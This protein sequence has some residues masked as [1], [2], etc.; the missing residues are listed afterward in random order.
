[1]TRA[2]QV[3]HYE[4]V[5]STNMVLRRLA[6]GGAPE[7]TVVWADRQTAGRGRTG[8]AWHSGGEWGLWF[9]ML[10]RPACAL[11]AQAGG[12]LPISAGV[13]VARSLSARLGLV[14]KIELKW[15]ND[16]LLGGRKVCGILCEAG[17]SGPAVDW[18]VVGV[19]I[20][21][22]TPPDGF[23]GEIGRTATALDQ[24][25]AAET[26]PSRAELLS[27][28]AAAVVEAYEQLVSE[29]PQPICAAATELMCSMIGRTVTCT[30]PYGLLSGRV[31]GLG[32]DGT[33][34][35]VGE[36]GGRFSVNA[37]DVHIGTRRFIEGD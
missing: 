16:V 30:T 1:M 37:G 11:P 21:V 25:M 2:L 35:L 14:G 4:E 5:D 8:R 23:P 26:L 24:H 6:C 9:S 32:P 10:L 29:G 31:T 15:P 22:F 7:G 19:G 18:A 36:G 27:E 13:G 12:M 28:V 20:N 34:A 3:I 33:L 17:L